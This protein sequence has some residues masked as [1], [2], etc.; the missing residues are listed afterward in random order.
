[1]SSGYP[2][3]VISK[4]TTDWDGGR[5]HLYTLTPTH[6]RWRTPGGIVSSGRALGAQVHSLRLALPRSQWLWYPLAQCGERIRR[7]STA[8]GRVR[9]LQSGVPES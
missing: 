6:A 8:A 4:F 3:R 7:H 5:V 2:G 9:R 1:M